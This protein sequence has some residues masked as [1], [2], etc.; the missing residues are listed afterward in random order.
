MSRCRMQT[1]VRAGPG[2]YLVKDFETSQRI[3][4]RKRQAVD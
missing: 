2:T 3:V 1:A 4:S